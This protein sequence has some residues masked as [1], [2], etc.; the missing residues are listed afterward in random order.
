MKS[1]TYATRLPGLRQFMR[2]RNMSKVASTLGI[3]QS[4][5]SLI[6]NCKRGAS[7]EIADKLAIYFGTTVSALRT[8]PEED[9]QPSV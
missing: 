4:S 5:L 7:A 9:L 3:N 6:V 2:D 1:H 8:A